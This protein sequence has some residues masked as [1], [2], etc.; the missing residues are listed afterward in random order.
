MSLEQAMEFI[1]DDELV[2]VTPASLRVRKALLVLGM[3]RS[4]TSAIT[5]VLSLLGADL[6]QSLMPPAA[7]DNV[8]GYWESVEIAALHDELL[9]AAMAVIEDGVSR[10]GDD[11]AGIETFAARVAGPLP[12]REI[13]AGGIEQLGGHL[14]RC[15]ETARN[16]LDRRLAEI[17][18]VMNAKFQGFEFVASTFTPSFDKPMI[19]TLVLREGRAYLHA[20]GA[21]V[22]DSDPRAEWRETLDKGR[23]LFA[24]LSGRE[25]EQ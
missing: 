15:A 10:P 22:A 1:E 14:P 3:H 17:P 7:G 4:G 18:P 16:P 21:V 19:R 13:D 6:P 12:R 2:E 5:R 11:L 25:D 8:R 9:A 23:G 20:G 24:A